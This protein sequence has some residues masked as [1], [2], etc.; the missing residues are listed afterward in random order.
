MHWQMAEVSGKGFD[1]VPQ[2]I[3]APLLPTPKAEFNSNALRAEMEPMPIATERL[4][5][6]QTL[7]ELLREMGKF[8][9]QCR[10]R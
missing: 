1:E 6:S 4:P 7:I 3:K 2:Q 10:G 9:C 5:Q 8:S